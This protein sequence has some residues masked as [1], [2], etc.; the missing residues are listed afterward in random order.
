MS[1]ISTQ[2]IYSQKY[3]KEEEAFNLPTL[4]SSQKA[5]EVR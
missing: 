2:R 4:W 3:C 1:V 5:G